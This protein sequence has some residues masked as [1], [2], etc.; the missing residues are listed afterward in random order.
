MDN[1]K[2]S[3]LTLNDV[4]DVSIVLKIGGKHYPLLPK[5]SENA[6]ELKSMRITLLSALLDSHIIINKP[7]EE[8]S[9]DVINDAITNNLNSTNE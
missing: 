5:K 1:E 3:N 2:L 9:R 8:I 6:K 7:I 4:E